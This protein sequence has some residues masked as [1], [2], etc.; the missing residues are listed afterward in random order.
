[1]SVAPLQALHA[2]GIG[3]A[4]TGV[5]TII[6]AGS[7]ARWDIPGP[8]DVVQLYLPQKTLER[9]A[10]LASTTAPTDLLE[11]TGHPDPI[12]SRL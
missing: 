10:G 9:V 8:V 3:T 7:S 4:R 5:V 1:F 12:T 2:G 11:R 6:P